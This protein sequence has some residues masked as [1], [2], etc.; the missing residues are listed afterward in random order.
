MQIKNSTQCEDLVIVNILKSLKKKGKIKLHNDELSLTHDVVV[1]M[2]DMID[3]LE[4]EEREMKS[5]LEE[6]F[7]KYGLNKE[8]DKNR[9]IEFLVKLYQRPVDSKNN[10]FL[11]I[12]V[13]DEFRTEVIDLIGAE[14]AML[15]IDEVKVLCCNN[16]F[17]NRVGS[18][19]TFISYYQNEDFQKYVSNRKKDIYLDTS[20]LAYIFCRNTGYVPLDAQDWDD[21]FYV[22]TI[23]LWQFQKKNK[24]NVRFFAMDG[25]IDELCGELQ[26]ALSCALFD[27]YEN[28]LF[29]IGKNTRNV[30]YNYFHFLRD[31]EYIEKTVSFAD[32]ITSL[33]FPNKVMDDSFRSRAKNKFITEFSK[34]DIQKQSYSERD[35]ECWNDATFQYDSILLA[36]K[37]NKTKHAM[38]IDIQ[39]TL[40]LMRGGNSHVNHINY[41]VSWDKTMCEL[42]DQLN[43]KHPNT[44]SFFAIYSPNGLLTTLSMENMNMDSSWLTDSIFAF[45]D[46]YDGTG[47]KMRSLVDHILLPLFNTDQKS[48]KF[49]NE[50]F[51]IQK[52]VFGDAAM[53]HESTPTDDRAPIEMILDDMR[54]AVQSYNNGTM[55]FSK[56]LLDEE[57]HE[58]V[59]NFYQSCLEKLKQRSYSFQ[60]VNKLVEHYKQYWQHKNDEYTNIVTLI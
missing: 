50:L 16:N 39:Q 3:N 2:K 48:I 56:Y 40:Y 53:E 58:F 17:F 20:L 14:R 60:M 24:N 42:R 30:F 33:G 8:T 29:Q 9:L 44:F 46:Q 51:L 26:K 45:A 7:S 13:L 15:L 52:Q 49:F 10:H 32:F 37:S 38:E 27:E 6:I 34:I 19:C 36:H 41:F 59:R 4:K 47:Q 18:S 57:N 31:R 11:K 43:E 22:K 5:G 54:K 55:N 23:Q 35:E 1:K 21:Y 12:S 25:Y 28:A